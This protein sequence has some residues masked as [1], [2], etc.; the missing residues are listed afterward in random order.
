MSSDASTP[1]HLDP[2]DHH[3]PRIYF[4]CYDNS[5]ESRCAVEH[6]ASL[7]RGNKDDIVHIVQVIRENTAEARS[8][9]EHVLQ[10]A[11]AI[12]TLY[13]DTILLESSII[14]S[15]DPAR[16]YVLFVIYL[17]YFDLLFLLFL[18]IR[19]SN[20]FLYSLFFFI[21]MIYLFYFSSLFFLI[22]MIYFV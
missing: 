3:L 17:F 12:A 14:V 20:S 9:A 22:I 15:H 1:P 7:A 10:G 5:P 8:D 13:N 21:I 19:H 4:V 16:A 6:A 2:K 18:F 11:K